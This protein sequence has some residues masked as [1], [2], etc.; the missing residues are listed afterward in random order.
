M[1]SPVKAWPMPCLHCLGQRELVSYRKNGD[2]LIKPCPYCGDS[3]I[4]GGRRLMGW[5][6][7]DLSLTPDLGRGRT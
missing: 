5:W 7:W 4:Q 1:D 2:V 6:K 3:K